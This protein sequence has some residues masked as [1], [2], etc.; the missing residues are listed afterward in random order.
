[1]IPNLSCDDRAHPDGKHSPD[2]PEPAASIDN[3]LA[4]TQGRDATI[5]LSRLEGAVVNRKFRCL[6]PANVF[7]LNQVAMTANPRIPERVHHCLHED[8]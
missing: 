8:T 3:L 1:M 2:M 7:S 5:M 4:V 6:P